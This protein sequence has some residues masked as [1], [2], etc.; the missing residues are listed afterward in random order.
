MPTPAGHRRRTP[1]PDQ[2]VAQLDEHGRGAQME[3]IPM[4]T[5]PQPQKLV[6]RGLV[7]IGLHLLA[8][9]TARRLIA[10]ALQGGGLADA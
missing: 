10:A 8:S 3:A 4:E 2:T 5:I 1:R 7:T 9:P 6:K